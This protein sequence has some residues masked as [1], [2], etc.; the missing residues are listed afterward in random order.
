MTHES[1]TH[2][3]ENEYR[4]VNEATKCIPAGATQQVLRG[5][6]SILASLNNEAVHIQRGH[7]LR[8]TLLSTRV[9]FVCQGEPPDRPRRWGFVTIR[10]AICHTNIHTYEYIYEY[11]YIH[12]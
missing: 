8:T 2:L 7:L 9:L 6:L 10:E 1:P 11:V 12:L 3:L 4:H 5:L